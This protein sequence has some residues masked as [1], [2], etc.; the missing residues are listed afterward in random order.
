MSLSAETFAS[1]L[2]QRLSAD[3]PSISA[4]SHSTKRSRGFFLAGFKEVRPH[5]IVIFEEE[6]KRISTK[7]VARF[8]SHES[9]S[10]TCR[11]F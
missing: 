5:K 10:H 6:K 7:S 1:V 8:V 3:L 4:K 9:R 11:A 2:V